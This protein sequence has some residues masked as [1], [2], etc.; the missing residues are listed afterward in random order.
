MSDAEIAKAAEEPIAYNLADV[1]E[2]GPRLSVN[3][4]TAAL[5]IDRQNRMVLKTGLGAMGVG[6]MWLSY[7][8]ER[9]EWA[10]LPER[11]STGEFGARA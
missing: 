4:K 5:A 11:D 2:H 10:D 1:F 9:S 7:D 6:T 3:R 8:E